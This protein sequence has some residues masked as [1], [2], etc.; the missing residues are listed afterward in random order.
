MQ[1]LA[2]SA[3]KRQIVSSPLQMLVPQIVLE[4][5]SRTFTRENVRTVTHQSALNVQIMR[6]NAPFVPM[7]QEET[8]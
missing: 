6:V 8:T 7:Y 5:N 3:V 2:L 4:V 1:Q